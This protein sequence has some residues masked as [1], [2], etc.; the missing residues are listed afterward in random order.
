[1]KTK[2]LLSNT[3]ADIREK[4][5]ITLQKG[6]R[7][8]LGP[9]AVDVA[10]PADVLH[11]QERLH[12]AWSFGLARRVAV[13]QS[14]RRFVAHKPRCHAHPGDLLASFVSV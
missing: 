2:K 8:E 9:S 13:K 1:M 4:A 14:L 11:L 5:K 12:W 6:P 10:P 7:H 3:A